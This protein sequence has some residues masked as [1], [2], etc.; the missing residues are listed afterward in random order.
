MFMEVA[1]QRRPNPVQNLPRLRFSMDRDE[2]QKRNC[3]VVSPNRARTSKT[4]GSEVR[5]G[6]RN[7]ERN[8]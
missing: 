4:R 3:F 5:N 6:V 8:W 2:S 1:D 7:W